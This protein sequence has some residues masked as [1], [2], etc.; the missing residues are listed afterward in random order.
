[1]LRDPGRV[2]LQVPQADPLLVVAPGLSSRQR[3][4]R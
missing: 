3:R 4:T 2:D 1:L